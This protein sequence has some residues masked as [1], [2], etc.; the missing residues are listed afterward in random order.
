MIKTIYFFF[1]F[2]LVF[3]ATDSF[4]QLTIFNVSSSEIT[5]KNKL[6]FQ[7]QFEIQDVIN[8]TTTA[9]YGLGKFWEVG[10]NVF[11]VNY[12]RATIP[13]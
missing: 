1:F 11:N 3:S 13:V 6:S 7:Q 12:E 9:T 4:A 5:E 8:S 10:V 2:V